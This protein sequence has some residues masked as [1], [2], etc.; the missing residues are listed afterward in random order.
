MSD[1]FCGGVLRAIDLAEFDLEQEHYLRLVLDGKHP[2]RCTK[3]E[4]IRWLAMPKWV[5]VRDGQHR[6]DLA[7]RCDQLLSD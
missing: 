1:R 5:V 3:C 7:Y 6:T 2:V 4:K